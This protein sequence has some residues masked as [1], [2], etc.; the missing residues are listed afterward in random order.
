MIHL[1]EKVGKNSL[2]IN[3]TTSSWDFGFIPQKKKQQI[4][5]T[6]KFINKF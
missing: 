2:A 6:R 3:F 4:N 1:S 5:R